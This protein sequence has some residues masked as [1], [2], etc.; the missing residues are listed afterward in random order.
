MQKIHLVIL[1]LALA[2]FLGGCGSGGTGPRPET[3]G[4]APG[5]RLDARE[6]VPG[7]RPGD[8]AIDPASFRENPV[9][10]AVLLPLSGPS[11]AVGEALLDAMT[12]AVFDA[13]DPRLE[14]IPLDTRG[15]AA[16]AAAAADRA[17]AME[18][19]I[20][21]GPLFSESARAVAE[22]V[23]GDIP[24]IAFSNDTDVAGNGVYLLSF[25]VSN[26]VERV[27]TYA[28][29]QGYKRF[30]ALIPETEYG[31][32][33]LDSLNSILHESAL[34]LAALE[35][36]E[37]NTED[38]FAPVRRLT[39]YDS[40][41]DA[42]E[43][44]VRFL[45]GLNDDLADELLERI[46]NQETF[47][48][49]GFDAVLLPEGGDLLRS[50]APVLPFYEVNPRDVKLLGTGLWDDSSLVR[51]PTLI[52]GWFAGAPR[53]GADTFLRRFEALY[54]YTPPRLA[55]LGYDAMGLAATLARHPIR[56]ERFS[57]T[58]IERMEGHRGVDGLF[59]FRTNG[60]PE[61]ALAIIE[62]TPEGLQV[63]DPAAETFEQ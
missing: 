60:T 19:D 45:Q 56:R 33:V 8:P 6:T 5:G 35:H 55:S 17:A 30:A 11:A 42:Y 27:L 9:R 15:T 47:G 61:R 31:R 34:E 22:R 54:G 46:E 52:G 37:S 38:L 43:A 25:T 62:I 39:R 14:V 36:Y 7:T 23:R 41:N 12:M 4:P 20:I 26:E 13:Y 44:E 57:R 48:E 10:I 3:A 2:I 29:E 24:V 18:A 32:K 40:R 16:A 28:H 21:L 50:L 63:I 1:W 58:L 51:E 59:R 53:E 49:T